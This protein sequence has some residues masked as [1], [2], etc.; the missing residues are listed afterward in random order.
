M[1]DLIALILLNLPWLVAL[2]I[3]FMLGRAVEQYRVK[4]RRAEWRA[5]NG[6][7]YHSGG[8]KSGADFAAGQLST[9]SR[10]KFTSRPLLNK[11]EANV[12]TALDK[13][14]IARNPGW[15]VMAQVSLGEFLASPD[16]QAFLSVNSKR[17]DFALMDDRCRVVHALEYQG[18]GHHTG[19]SAAARDA[20]KKE[21]L[22]KA[23]IGYHE[24]V[25][26]HTTA[27]ELRALV[28]KLVPV[29]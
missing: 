17:V 29:G 6:P 12:F 3:A 9:V 4:V 25:A 18:S 7:K 16:K 27:G 22:R 28:E 23:G 13:A 8:K 20:V 14:V 21:A 26:G 2:V 19:N 5:K 15:Q 24:V 1:D 11:S 10:A